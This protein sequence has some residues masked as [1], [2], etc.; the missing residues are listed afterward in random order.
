MVR[1]TR[2]SK[3]RKAE[4]S[5]PRGASRTNLKTGKVILTTELTSHRRLQTTVVATVPP[6]RPR[7]RG[8]T[9]TTIPALASRR[10]P[11][12]TT[13]ILLRLP[14]PDIHRSQVTR[15]TRRRNPDFYSFQRAA[16]RRKVSTSS[17]GSTRVS[18]T[19]DMK[20]VSPG[21]RG[22][23]WMWTCSATPAPAAAPIFPPMLKA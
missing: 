11:N 8:I 4:Q 6:I 13:T 22:T 18:P 23:T 15:K 16:I 1:L 10:L 17:S 21:Q 20:L 14:P 7:L 19:V 12:S 3:R 5:T 9:Q 2:S